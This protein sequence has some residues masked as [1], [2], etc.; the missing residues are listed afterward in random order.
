MNNNKLTLKSLLAFLDDLDLKNKWIIPSK[1]F[2]V[3][4]DE[5]DN[6]L[7]KKLNFFVESGILMYLTKGF[8]ANKRA[9]SKTAFFLEEMAKYFRPEDLFYESLESMASEFSLISQIPNR[10]TLVTSGRSYLYNTPLGI[11][12]F[13][14]RK[15]DYEKF[16]KF[17][18]ENMIIYDNIKKIYCAKEYLIKKDLIRSN[19]AV[20]LMYEQEE[21]I[22]YA[23]L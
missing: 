23:N 5:K 6:T 14:H 4:F 12:E 20:D 22:N 17:I 15:L 21:E 11:I 10:L 9:R 13:T 8:Y 2:R 1:A 7:Y 18:K 19:R 16:Q 3:V